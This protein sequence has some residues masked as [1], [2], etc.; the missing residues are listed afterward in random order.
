MDVNFETHREIEP[1]PASEYPL[2]QMRCGSSYA[3][4][5]YLTLREAAA[6]L[7]R[8]DKSETLNVDIGEYVKEANGTIRKM[9]IEDM[10]LIC[11]EAEKLKRGS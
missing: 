4:R 10:Q 11:G 2:F 9:L 5:R 3:E 8:G 1:R 6:H 7:V